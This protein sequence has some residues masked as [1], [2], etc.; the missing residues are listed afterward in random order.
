MSESREALRFNWYEKYNKKNPYHTLQ[1]AKERDD[2][3]LKLI[4]L[5]SKNTQTT[6]E[7][8]PERSLRYLWI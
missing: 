1:Q 4:L 3:F 5:L 6:E 8:N 2:L 7:P